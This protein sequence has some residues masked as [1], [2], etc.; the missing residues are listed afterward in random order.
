[1]V[2]IIG[3]F[4]LTLPLSIPRLMGYEVYEVST[5]SGKNYSVSYSDGVGITVAGDGDTITNSEYGYELPSTG[6]P[7]TTVFYILGS[8]L[9]LLAA[10]LLITKRRLESL[11]RD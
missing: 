6:G 4:V 5:K 11:Q 10:A 3:V 8:T 9:T 2:L 7:G 1:M